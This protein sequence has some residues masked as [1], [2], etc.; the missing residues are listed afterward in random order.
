MKENIENDKVEKI[1]NAG[2]NISESKLMENKNEKKI[3][4]ILDVNDQTDK[5]QTVLENNNNNLK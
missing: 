4:I 1:S 2:G 3:H 5:K